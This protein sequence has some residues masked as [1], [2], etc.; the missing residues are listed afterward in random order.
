MNKS[1]DAARRELVGV[2]DELKRRLERIRADAA[3]R[4]APVSADWTDRAQEQENDEVLDRLESSTA[5]LLS[6]HERAIARIDQGAYGICESCGLA[7]D[8]GRLLAIPQATQC[9][10]CAGAQESRAA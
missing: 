4:A 7:I 10:D 9:S 3:H 5:E 2:L 1:P 6:Q 8:E